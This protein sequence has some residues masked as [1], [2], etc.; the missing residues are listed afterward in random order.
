MWLSLILTVPGYISRSVAGSYDNEGIAI[1]ALQFTY[2]LWVSSDILLLLRVWWQFSYA[3]WVPRGEQWAD[4]I[5]GQIWFHRTFLW[6]IQDTTVWDLSMFHM[7]QILLVMNLWSEQFFWMFKVWQLACCLSFSNETLYVN[8][9]SSSFSTCVRLSDCIVLHV[10]VY[11]SCET[12]VS[13][14][15][16]VVTYFWAVL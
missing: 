8:V 14:H 4:C 7:W 10:H 15:K 16:R 1:F 12:R 11:P 3:I 13:Y 5:S 6:N 9:L 2:F